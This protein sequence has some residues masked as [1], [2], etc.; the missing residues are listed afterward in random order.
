M[1]EPIRHALRTLDRELG[2]NLDIDTVETIRHHDAITLRLPDQHLVVRLVTRTDDNR[3]RAHR[4]VN[5][6]TW[7]T[8][9]GFPTTRPAV[10][11]PLELE[12]HIATVWHE[13]PPRPTHTT[14]D[15]TVAL[16]RLLRSLHELPTPPALPPIAEPLERIRRALDTDSARENP[17]LT[18]AEKGFLRD[19]IQNLT[20]EYDTLAFPLGHGLI[21]NDAH[22]ANALATPDS[23]LGYVL[24]DWGNAGIGPREMDIVLVGAPGSRF[25]DTEKQRRAFSDAYGYDIAHWPG[26]TTL[27]DIRDLHAL[28]AYIRTAPTNPAAANQLR[29][30]LRSLLDNNRSIIWRTT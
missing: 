9:Q 7:L 12:D 4:T 19:R 17:V 29:T 15:A 30:R 6:T 16:G 26:H 13:V 22:T 1:R 14:R 2:L 10:T 23:P 8:T 25:G 28:A 3:N 27:R 5:L 24:T 20:D 21:H 11:Q 18:S